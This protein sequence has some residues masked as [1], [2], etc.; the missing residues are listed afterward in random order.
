MSD[1]SSDIQMTISLDELKVLIQEAVRETLLEM[2]GED[3]NSEPT[4]AP[5]IAERLRKYQQE[6]L[7]D[8]L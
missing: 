7:H 8:S 2:F 1:E 6:K 3:M 4:F 5:E